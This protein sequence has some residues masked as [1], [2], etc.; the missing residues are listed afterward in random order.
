MLAPATAPIAPPTHAPL[1]WLTLLPDGRADAG[2]DSAPS[3]G[4]PADARVASVAVVKVVAM[5]AITKGFFSMS[6][7]S[8]SSC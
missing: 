5:T 6:F 1:W 3:A 8:V 4:S 2:A 7:S